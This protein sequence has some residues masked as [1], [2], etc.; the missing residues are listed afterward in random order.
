MIAAPPNLGATRPDWIAERMNASAAPTGYYIAKTP[1][2]DVFATVRLVD[3]P[4]KNFSTAAYMLALPVWAL[5]I[6]SFA[7]PVGFIGVGVLCANVWS[8]SRRLARI[9]VDG[10]SW[11][12]ANRSTIWRL[13]KEELFILMFQVLAIATLVTIVG[14]IAFTIAAAIQLFNIRG[15]IS[16]KN[17]PEWMQNAVLGL[18]RDYPR[19]DRRVATAI[20]EVPVIPSVTS[21]QLSEMQARM[22]ADF[23]RLP[24]L[25]P[26]ETGRPELIKAWK[27]SNTRY[28]EHLLREGDQQTR[29]AWDDAIGIFNAAKDDVDLA[30]GGLRQSV[31]TAETALAAYTIDEASIVVERSGTLEGAMLAARLAPKSFTQQLR[32][33]RGTT[34]AMTKVAT[35]N[36]PWQAAAGFAA[37]SLIMM[38]VNHSKLMRQLKELEGQLVGQA[39]AVRG[40]I[41]LIES[42]LRLRLI[43]QFDGLAALLVRLQNGLADLHAAEVVVGHGNAK[44][45][46]F[47]L[48]CAVREAQ[49]LLEMK[50]GN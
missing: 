38:G 8:V 27:D 37:F 48:A 28:L 34:V 22:R 15:R 2:G 16:E 1:A 14:P 25:S 49:Y 6:C 47:H 13:M 21:V 50:A 30:R 18:V 4:G 35:G 40:D 36:L 44:A 24:T 32:L 39:E 11:W 10:G 23:D 7:Y 41:T 20:I 31:T 46:A 12:Y 29:A 43:P 3:Q 9:E 33:D 5:F 17:F 26:F 45:E 19:S 42:E